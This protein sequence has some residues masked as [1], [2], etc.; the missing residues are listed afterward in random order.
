MSAASTRGSRLRFA[1]LILAVLAPAAVLGQD[2]AP[3]APPPGSSAE[4]APEAAPPAEPAPADAASA[5][6]APAD[7]EP[8]QPG[9]EAD[10]AQAPEQAP[11]ATIPV[12]QRAQAAPPPLPEPSSI[13]LDEITVTA[14]KRGNEAIK[15]VPISISVV[16]DELIFDWGITNVR[17]VMLFVPNVKVEEAGYFMLPRIRGF[18]TNNNNRAFEPPA[19]VAFDGIPYGRIEYFNAGLFDVKRVEVMRGPQGTTF[20]KNTTAGLIHILTRD[21]TEDFEGFVDLQRGEFDRHRLEFGIGGPLLEDFLNVRLSGLEDTRRG[22]VFNTTHALVPE[23]NEYLQ[24]KD[25]GGLRAKLQFPDLLGTQLKISYEQMELGSLGS[26]IEAIDL[27]DTMEAALRKYDPNADFIKGNFITSLDTPDYRRTDIHSWTGEWSSALAEWNLTALGG[28]SEMESE[29]SLDTDFSPAPAIIGSGF[30]RAPTKTLELRALSPSFGLGAFGEGDI[31]VGVFTQRTGIEDGF[32]DFILPLGPFLDLTAAAEGSGNTDDDPPVLSDI[33]G[34]VPPNGV[35]LDRGVTESIRQ[36]FNQHSDTRAVFSQVQWR[37]VPGWTL[38]LG[39]RYSAEDKDGWWDSQFTSPTFVALTA[40]GFTQFETQRERSD[41]FFQPKVSLNWQPTGSLSL[42]VHWARS[43]KSGGFNA[44]AFRNAEDQLGYKPEFTREWGADIKGTFLDR[45]LRLNLS[46]Y[47]MDVTDFQV[48]VRQPGQPPEQAPTIGLGI[49]KVI[50]APKARAQGIEGDVTWL[51]ASWLRWF[52]TIGINATE[53]LDHKNN[54]CPVD[55]D[56]SSKPFCDAT[57]KRFAFAP[58]ENGSITAALTSPWTFLGGIEPSLSMSGEYASWQYTDIDL[59]ERKI[60]DA[61][62]RW[63]ASIG[64][65]QAA[66]GWSFKI[67]GENLTNEVTYIRQG[68]LA[69]KQFVGI[70]EP[71]RQIYGQF[72]WTF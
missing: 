3:D 23:A 9:P 46:A 19:G 47:R 27:T 12:P 17:E 62:W 51:T 43:F 6:P 11:P 26:G 40:A 4:P 14:Q 71:P 61:Y 24:G 55:R 20:G 28:T 65:A 56:S 32:F 49:S 41:S 15:D 31:L 52:V 63:R 50:N 58:R 70:A 69:P 36:Y 34:L 57:G 60:Q 72:R 45:T 64:I 66:Q 29:F 18:T 68:D 48:L 54:D 44:F 42:F 37:F 2:A 67:I 38:A 5:E 59:D 7:A 53:Y 30:D 16:D 22:F 35:F 21:P 33:L 1:A 39:G 8:A 10:A 13:Q 25:N